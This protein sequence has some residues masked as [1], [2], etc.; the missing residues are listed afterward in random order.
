MVA[1]DVLSRGQLDDAGKWNTT[2]PVKRAVPRPSL[3]GAYILLLLFM[4]IYCA[5]P[6]DWIP[7]LAVVPLAKISGFLALAALA[8]SIWNTRQRLPREVLYLILLTGQLFTAAFMSPVWPGGAFQRTLDFAK[9]L[10]IFI[11]IAVSVQTI[12]RL[13]FLIFVQAMSVAVIATVTVWKGQFLSGRLEGLLGGDYSD[14]NDLALAIIISL[15]L[16]LVLLFLGKGWFWKSI[17]TVA[18]LI[19]IYAVLLTGSR[20]GFITL[21]VT[22]AI[23]LWEFGIQ[24]RRHLLLVIAVLAGIALWQSSS[25][26]MSRRLEGTF[27]S[28]IDGEAA[29]ASAQTRQLLFW[30]SVEVTKE[31]PFF[32]VGPGNFDAVSGQW[33]TTHNSFT[34]MSSEGGIPA[35]VLYVLILWCGFKNLRIAKRLLRMQTQARLMAEALFASL[36]GFVLGSLFLSVAYDFLPYILVAYSSAL[37]LIARKSAAQSRRYESI[38]QSAVDGTV[39]LCEPG[40]EMYFHIS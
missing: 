22:A 32:G 12:T 34:L 8:L 31:H 10:L 23:C 26:L 21:I 20:G 30:R 1:I 33:H 28:K 35:L 14:P 4:L 24:R 29:Y 40:S 17:W 3:L 39:F 19:M 27:D 6:E 5:R 16:C 18:M 36:A 25:S 37:F 13:R 11:V 38:G 9:V 2:A 7:G 15:P